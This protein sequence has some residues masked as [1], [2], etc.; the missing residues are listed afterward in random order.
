MRIQI[1]LDLLNNVWRV[2][3]LPIG[4][5]CYLTPFG[6][7]DLEVWINVKVEEEDSVCLKCLVFIL[8]YIIHNVKCKRLVYNFCHLSKYT[9]MS[10]ER[11][12]CFTVKVKKPELS[13]KPRI[14]Y[15][16]CNTLFRNMVLLLLYYFLIFHDD[17]FKYWNTFNIEMHC[18]KASE[19]LLRGEKYPMSDQSKS[20]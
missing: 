18:L 10:V 20:A 15:Y 5:C 7:H 8:N 13:F 11:V 1:F 3:H 9:W 16:K 14:S 4:C 6:I 17:I 12:Y 19:H 2:S